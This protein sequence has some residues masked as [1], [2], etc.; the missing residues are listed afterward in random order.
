MG[1]WAMESS[2][3]KGRVACAVDVGEWLMLKVGKEERDVE[4]FVVCAQG[5]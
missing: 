1:Q 4:R 5:V 3:R 2:F